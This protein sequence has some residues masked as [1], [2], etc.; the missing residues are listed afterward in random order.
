M[1]VLCWPPCCRVVTLSLVEDSVYKRTPS[2]VMKR[3]LRVKLLLEMVKKMLKNVKQKSRPGWPL[4]PKQT[5]RRRVSWLL[6]G[7]ASCVCCS[8]RKP[9][10]NSRKRR[11]GRGNREG[12]LWASAVVKRNPWIKSQ[13]RVLGILSRNT[14]TIS[15]QQKAA[16]MILR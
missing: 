1:G 12:E 15:L 10:R 7:K 9:L 16:N 2:W 6:P 4:K 14:K 5:R 3:N 8:E 13:L 11:R